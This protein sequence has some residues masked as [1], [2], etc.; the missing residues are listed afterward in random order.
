MTNLQKQNF[1]SRVQRGADLS[2]LFDQEAPEYEYKVKQDFV[3]LIEQ[4]RVSDLPFR[5]MSDDRPSSIASNVIDLGDFDSDDYAIAVT[6]KEDTIQLADAATIRARRSDSKGPRERSASSLAATRN[7]SA[8]DLVGQRVQA[9]DFAS[10][11]QD[12][13]RPQSGSDSQSG[14]EHSLEKTQV[15]DPGRKTMDW[16]FATATP[17]SPEQKGEDSPST[18]QAPSDRTAKHATME[19]SFSNA[20][21]E[22]GVDSAQEADEAQATR[23]TSR[24]APLLRTMTQPVT[25]HEVHDAEEIP[26][27]STSRSEAF[28]ESSFSSADGD[29]FA[30]ERGQEPPDP[31]ALD[32]QALSAFYDTRGHS[33]QPSNGI[34]TIPYP[35]TV[36]GPTPHTY[37]LA[38]RIGEGGFPD[39]TNTYHVPSLLSQRTPPVTAQLGRQDEV[40]RGRSWPKRKTKKSS[41]SSSQSSGSAKGTSNTNGIGRFRVEMPR[42]IPPDPRVLSGNA[43]NEQVESEFSRL[44][45]HFRD[46]LNGASQAV[47]YLM[48]PRRRSTKESN[49]GG[50]GGYG[51]VAGLKSES[52]WTD[53]D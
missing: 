27:P 43:S 49:G 26:R 47:G 11:G 17:M 28:S 16:T 37:G 46:A 7:S 19:W 31:T 45:D 53:E 41:T 14:D 35:S 12:Q 34:G 9:Q 18:A 51:N 33:L 15:R 42:P 13:S 25:F 10:S 40:S 1:E 50:G 23:T 8:D 2:N 32:S 52:E 29:P 21:A 38:T 5:A 44:L 6:R 22:V 48:R 39:S 4:R 30:L 3:P 24:R 20:Y 36:A